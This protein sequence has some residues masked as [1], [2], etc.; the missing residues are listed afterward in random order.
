MDR[1]NQEQVAT[2]QLW[3]ALAAALLGWMFD[4]LEMGLFPLVARPAL[5]SLSPSADERE[6]GRWFAVATASFL[7]GAATGGVLFGWL[8]D[9]LGRVRA[10]SLSVLTYACFSGACGLARSPA[11][12]AGLRFASAL[13]MG[14]E[15]AL[16]VALVMEIW[17]DRS[18][19]MLAGLIGA[20]SNVGYV[21]IA[22]LGLILADVQGQLPHWLSQIGFSARWV[23]ILTAGNGWRLLMF[24]GAWPALLALLIQAFVPESRKWKREQSRG[25]TS[26]WAARD[27]WGVLVG[28]AGAWMLIYWWAGDHPWGARLAG[29]LVAMLILIAG[30]V[31]PA[32]QYLRRTTPAPQFLPRRASGYSEAFPDEE[33][34][35]GN[36]AESFRGASEGP[37]DRNPPAA[38]PPSLPY[39]PSTIPNP[40]RMILRRMGLGACLSGVALLGT[41]ASVQWA[42]T[43][44]D[45]LAGGLPQA[46]AYTQ[47]CTGVGAVIGTI[48]AALMG[49]WIG[50]RL[51]YFLLCAGS[52]GVSLLFFLGMRS[53]GYGPPFL[54][55]AFLVGAVTASFYG[56]LPLYLP[57]LFPTRVR[58]TG[59]GFSYNFGRVI[60][61]VGV[62]QVGSLMSYFGGSYWRACSTMSLV[63]VIGAAIIWLAPET[64]GQPLPE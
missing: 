55:C 60:A 49:G 31:Y 62:L 2:R 22:L 46:K 12:V 28:A 36:A 8:G 21:L 54:A 4:G 58:A 29:S 20:A 37:R 44:A 43:W 7:V 16:G 23:A 30:Y 14:G 42:P 18:R 26:H 10:M 11:Q 15:W 38:G 33:S 48:V 35:P 6:I 51:T 45:Q 5:Q 47:I 3:L 25:S 1:P 52:L 40:R 9:R 13:G 32:Y 56:W 61:A 27:L 17:P 19:A 64:K 63:Y 24:V 41:W 57:E 59:Q 53:Y 39:E 34:H 50:R